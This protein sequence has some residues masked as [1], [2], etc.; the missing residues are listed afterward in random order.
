MVQSVSRHTHTLSLSSGWIVQGLHSADTKR[1]LMWTAV[2][3]VTSLC[4]FVYARTQSQAVAPL[5]R[6]LTEVRNTNTLTKKPPWAPDEAGVF[7][8]RTHNVRFLII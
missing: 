5:S 8:Y 4:L 3:C 6:A 7:Q 1:T 2:L